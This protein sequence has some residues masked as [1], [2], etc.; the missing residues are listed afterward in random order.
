MNITIELLIVLFIALMTD[1]HK[2]R[3][4]LIQFALLIM[5]I[6]IYR[7]YFVFIDDQMLTGETYIFVLHIINI[8]TIT[9]KIIFSIF[10]Y[11]KSEKH[12]SA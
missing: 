9:V 4:I 8:I 3:N 11:Q 12:I 7:D 2:I 5:T 6:N 1:S 10:V